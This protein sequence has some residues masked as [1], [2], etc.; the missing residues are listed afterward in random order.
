MAQVAAGVP[1]AAWSR[2]G[3]GRPRQPAKWHRLRRVRVEMPRARAASRGN[4]KKGKGCG[5][6]GGAIAPIDHR[7]TATCKM[8]QVAL[9]RG[10]T[11]LPGMA[12]LHLGHFDLRQRSRASGRPAP[13]REVLARSRLEARGIFGLS[14][15]PRGNLK[16]GTGCGGKS[17]SACAPCATHR[18]NLKNGKG[19]GGS[20][21]ELEALIT[22]DPRQPE[23]WQRLRRPRAFAA[24][25][26]RRA[27]GNLKNGKGCGGRPRPGP[28]PAE[29]AAAPWTMAKDA[30]GHTAALSGPNGR[31]RRK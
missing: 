17:S 23:K 11:M 5:G 20:C 27:R 21:A 2:P 19:C 1:V 4:L 24:S 7:P 29:C 13:G 10:P 14:R 22:A 28:A 25:R 26:G 9:G 31:T 18:G 12:L 15:R 3:G 16:N 8:A 6:R 30:A